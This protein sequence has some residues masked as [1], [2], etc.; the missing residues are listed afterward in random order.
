LLPRA[1]GVEHENLIKESTLRRFCGPGEV[2]AYTQMTSEIRNQA[3]HRMVEEAKRL[4]AN[5]IT[6]VRFDSDEIGWGN[7]STICYGTAV[8][9]E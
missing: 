6:C 8:V 7:T 9:V 3:L 2:T 4:G 5:A 1:K